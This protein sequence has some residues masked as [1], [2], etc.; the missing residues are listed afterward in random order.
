[1]IGLCAFIKR[2]L[3]QIHTNC[4]QSQLPFSIICL[5]NTTTSLTMSPC[6]GAPSIYE[7]LSQKALCVVF[8]VETKAWVQSPVAH[9]A[10]SGLWANCLT[11][12]CLLFLIYK[13]G[14][15]RIPVSLVWI[16]NK[17]I[18]LMKCL[19]KHFSFSSVNASC[20]PTLLYL[21]SL[22]SEE[23]AHQPSPQ[24]YCNFLSLL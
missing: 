2:L 24:Q 4:W 22:L 14:V 16:S 17:L 23:R 11:S 19:Q 3:Y 6:A 13:M 9:V 12:L 1:M 8:K 18:D 5:A 20:L 21:L 10:R 15:I 7:I